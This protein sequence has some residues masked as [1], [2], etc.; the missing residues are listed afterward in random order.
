[1]TTCFDQSGH[2]QV[3]KFLDEETAIFYCCLCC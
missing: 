3:L 2:H 1:M